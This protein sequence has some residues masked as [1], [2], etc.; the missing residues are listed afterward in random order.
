[1]KSIQT[2]CGDIVLLSICVWDKLRLSSGSPDLQTIVAKLTESTDFQQKTT[3]MNK[4]FDDSS[5]EE[6]DPG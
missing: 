6:T 3:A 1:M 5:I 2:I 4:S